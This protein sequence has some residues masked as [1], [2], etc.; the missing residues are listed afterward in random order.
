MGLFGRKKNV[1]EGAAFDA[2]D[3]GGTAI[4]LSINDETQMITI[5][6]DLENS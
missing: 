6:K 4:P 1:D 2:W 5:E 3:T